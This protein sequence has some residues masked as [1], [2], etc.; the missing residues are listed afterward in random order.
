[1]DALLAASAASSTKLLEVQRRSCDDL[2]RSLRHA[3]QTRHEDKIKSLKTSLWE[4]RE[5]MR[6]NTKF[7]DDTRSNLRKKILSDAQIVCCTLSSSGHDILSRID[8]E[9][10]I[11]DEACQAVELSCLVPLQHNCRQCILVGGIQ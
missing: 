5:N 4:A 6:K 1:V 10:L 11:I 7:L 3:E 2:K 9:Y 8:F